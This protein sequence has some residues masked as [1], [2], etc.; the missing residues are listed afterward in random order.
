MLLLR[1]GELRLSL[2]NL[3]THG[4]KRIEKERWLQLRFKFKTEKP[5]N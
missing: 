5:E 4:L 3:R 1:E 2:G